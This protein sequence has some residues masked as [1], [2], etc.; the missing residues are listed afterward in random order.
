M[1]NCKILAETHLLNQ[2]PLYAFN[3][4]IAL[5]VGIV[6]FGLSKAFKWSSN[7]YINQILIPIVAF[8]LTMVIIDVISRLM[9]SKQEKETIMAQCMMTKENFANKMMEKP[10]KKMM[11]ETEEYESFANKMMAKPMKKMMSETEEY[12]S[13]N[14]MLM[15]A[16][17]SPSANVIL[18]ENIKIKEAIESPTTDYTSYSPMPLESKDFSG[19]KCIEPSNSISLC[20]G[21]GPETNPYH[22]VTAIPGPQWLPQTAAAVQER[23]KNNDYSA[24][25]CKL[26]T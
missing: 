20:S 1:E 8:L 10:L 26:G 15:V 11:S 7:S 2:N 3:F 23:L 19:A 9:I 25:Q 24:A 6:F 18:E 4:P 16:A 13:F 14:N 12:E 17:E 5:L 22:L 21:S